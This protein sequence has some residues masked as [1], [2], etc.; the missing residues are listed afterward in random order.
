MTALN[1]AGL[2]GESEGLC[3]DA[4]QARGIGQVEPGLDAVRSRRNTGI[5]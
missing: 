1:L 2:G 3:R 5:L 4:E